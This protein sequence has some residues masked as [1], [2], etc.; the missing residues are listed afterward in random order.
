MARFSRSLNPPLYSDYKKYRQLLRVDFRYRCAYCERTESYLRSEEVFEIDHFKPKR[1]RELLANYQNL[2][3]SCHKCNLYKSD[4]W[5]SDTELSEGFRFSD[6]CAEDMYV[7]HLRE[8]ADGKLEALTN[9]G[10]FTYNRIRLYRPDLVKWRQAKRIAS[11]EVATFARAVENLA[12]LAGQDANT[13]KRE[14]ILQ[15]IAALQRKIQSDREQ[16]L[17]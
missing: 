5:P 10:Q 1:F 13:S 2:Y 15:Q 7:E 9:C 17:L 4:T 11:E 3:Y 12:M 6:P 16:F 14:S 8:T